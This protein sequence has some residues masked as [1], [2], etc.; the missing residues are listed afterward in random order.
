MQF[1]PSLRDILTRL[2][3]DIFPRIV[4][5]T[6]DVEAYF[7][8][9]NHIVQWISATFCCNCVKV[10]NLVQMKLIKNRDF[11]IQIKNRLGGISKFQNFS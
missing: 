8:Y 2:L 11:T 1:D 5:Q 9:S 3:L 6:C 4:H 10:P 7:F